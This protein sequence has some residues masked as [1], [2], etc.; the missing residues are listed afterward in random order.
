MFVFIGWDIMPMLLTLE[1][2]GGI[3]KFVTTPIDRKTRQ[4]VT[5]RLAMDSQGRDYTKVLILGMDYCSP[6]AQ[7][8]ICMKMPTATAS[9]VVK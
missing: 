3:Y 2:D 5:K 7:S 6:P 8:R 9:T 4:Y 1:T